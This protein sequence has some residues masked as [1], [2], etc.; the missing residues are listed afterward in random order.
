MSAHP[1]LHPGTALLLLIGLGTYLHENGQLLTFSF[2][3]YTHVF[4][5]FERIQIGELDSNVKRHM[6]NLR[7]I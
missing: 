5:A 4:V 2:P 6:V 1:G 3:T 7:V